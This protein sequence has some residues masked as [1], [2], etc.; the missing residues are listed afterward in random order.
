MGNVRSAWRAGNGRDCLD[1]AEAPTIGHIGRIGE[2]VGSSGGGRVC[3]P[4]RREVGSQPSLQCGHAAWRRG[5]YSPLRL[6]PWPALLVLPI[7]HWIELSSPRR[8]RWSSAGWGALGRVACAAAVASEPAAV[9]ARPQ[10][11]STVNR[12]P[13]AAGAVRAAGDVDAG[14][15]LHELIHRLCCCRVGRRHG[16]QR[17][18]RGHAMGFG[19]WRE[20]TAQ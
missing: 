18:S 8:S 20:Q 11:R 12:H 7:W 13:S 1:E 2:R 19:C 17:P 16:Q 10:W 5:R 14:H 15:A 6:G 4:R 3:G 9:V